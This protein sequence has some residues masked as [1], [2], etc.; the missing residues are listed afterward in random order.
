M[1]SVLIIF[2]EED[3][4]FVSMKVESDLRSFEKNNLTER[5]SCKTQNEVIIFQIIM[6]S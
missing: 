4:F 5:A 2:D 3:T 6:Q 1:Y